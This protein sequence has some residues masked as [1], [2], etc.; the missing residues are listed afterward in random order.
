VVCE[1]L[2]G[3]ILDNLARHGIFRAVANVWYRKEDFLES[4]QE[5]SGGEVLFSIV[6][7][8]NLLGTGG[9]IANVAAHVKPKGTFIVHTGDIFSNIDLT[10]AIRP[11]RASGAKLTFLVRRGAR[12]IFARANE[13]VDINGQIGAESES[14]GKFTG[15]SIWEPEILEFMPRPGTPGGAVEG[16]ISAIRELPGQILIHDIG[17][18]LWTDIGTPKN[19]LELHRKLL[20][21][22]NFV[23]KGVKFSHGV[24]MRGNVCI[25]EGARIA[26]GC[27]LRD[28]VIW[29]GC[30]IGLGTILDGAIVGPF[31]IYRL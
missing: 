7:E 31:G 30:E 19:Y 3:S 13:V 4:A 12:E 15:I 8:E 2:L 28:T 22:E 17:D 10:S 9:G 18:A 21:G 1:P 14:A 25:C 29:P 5:R 16:W 27:S 23:A 26:S 24:Q 11:H 6:P 20:D